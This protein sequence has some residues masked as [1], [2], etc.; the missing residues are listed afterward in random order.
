MVGPCGASC[1]KRPR[2]DRFVRSSIRIWCLKSQQLFKKFCPGIRYR[3]WMKFTWSLGIFGLQELGES[4]CRSNHFAYIEYC[5]S[6]EHLL[7]WEQL[8]F[9]YFWLQQHRIA[10]R[11]FRSPFSLFFS[12]TQ[13]KKDFVGQFSFA[14]RIFNRHCTKPFRHID[15]I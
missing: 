13:E 15:Y 6:I 9:S 11:V 8:L 5:L 4:S 2:R 1:L 7:L 12:L 14:S 10:R 3:N